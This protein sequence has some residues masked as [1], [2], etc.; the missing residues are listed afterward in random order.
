MP[1]RPAAVLAAVLLFAPLAASAA[2]VNNPNVPTGEGDAIFAVGEGGVLDPVAVRLH[3]KFL[4]P[5]SNEG[6]PSSKLRSE[7]N[8]S[9]LTAGSKVHVIFG[10]RTI[11]TV[12]AKVEN[13][14][15]T[16]AIPP[17]LHL[18]L[19]V[20]ALASPTLSGHAAT[21]RRAPT[22]AERAAA[23][24]AA[25]KSTGV[26]SPSRFEVSNLTAMDLGHGTAVVGTL[27][28]RGTGTPRKDKR[29]F[30]IAE[31]VNGALRTT[32]LN[33]QTIRVTEPLLEEVSEH[34][35]DAID[36]GDGTLSV[37][38]RMTGYDAYTYAIY[39]RKSGGW[40]NV[41][42]GGGVAA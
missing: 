5:G 28:V 13:G 19:N 33:L 41:Y 16:I 37:V 12:P 36:L 1:P 14:A 35:V 40:K 3:G 27:N 25:A 10:G 7:S 4:N 20:G 23:L 8:A 18:N 24:G 34:L 11:A 21:P 29:I 22:A 26:A 30:F 6:E 17:S 39:T 32:L 38:T 9:L 15:A 42:T 31:P 2:S